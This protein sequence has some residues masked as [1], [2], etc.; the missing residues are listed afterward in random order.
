MRTEKLVSLVTLAVGLVQLAGAAG[1]GLAAAYVGY[2]PLAVLFAAGAA[3]N[4]FAAATTV[5]DA[6]FGRAS[7]E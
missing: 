3:V 6:L 5:I 7:E 2:P 4:G 1:C